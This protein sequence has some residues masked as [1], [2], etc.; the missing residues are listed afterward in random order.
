MTSPA[1][2]SNQQQPRPQAR[3]NQPKEDRTGGP[4][5]SCET[6]DRG[7]ASCK[8]SMIRPSTDISAHSAAL[9]IDTARPAGKCRCTAPT[10][11]R[12]RSRNSSRSTGSSVGRGRK[13]STTTGF[14]GFV[15]LGG[16]PSSNARAIALRTVSCGENHSP[17]NRCASSS[18]CRRC[19]SVQSPGMQPIKSISQGHPTWRLASLVSGDASAVRPILIGPSGRTLTKYT[20]TTAPRTAAAARAASRAQTPPTTRS[21][22]TGPAARARPR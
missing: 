7:K 20:L 13:G 22:T 19:S 8:M 16:N 3:N 12:A 17:R 6:D 4:G 14:S 21:R 2:P 9:R 15:D 18:S 11:P 5:V 1:T 10:S